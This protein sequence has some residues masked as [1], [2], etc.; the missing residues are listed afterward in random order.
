M[1][2]FEMETAHVPMTQEN[3]HDEITNEDNAHHFLQHQVYYLL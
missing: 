1:T 3:S 2:K